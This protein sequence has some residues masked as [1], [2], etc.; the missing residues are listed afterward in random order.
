[1]AFTLGNPKDYAAQYSVP[2]DSSHVCR[3][4]LYSKNMLLNH[5]LYSTLIDFQSK[6]TV[7]Q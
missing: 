2:F 1:M 7:F 6:M 3:S 5:G 4:V